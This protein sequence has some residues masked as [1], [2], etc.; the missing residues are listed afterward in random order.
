MF[1]FPSWIAFLCVAAASVLW[2]TYLG[3]WKEN[4]AASRKKSKLQKSLTQS[5]P[6]AKNQSRKN[7]RKDI[8][9]SQ[10]NHQRLQ[11]RIDSE[12]SLLTFQ[13][14]DKSNSIEIIEQLNGIQC[15]SQEKM[16]PSNKLT[17]HQ[18]RYLQA[19]EGTYHYKTQTFEAAKAVL[20]L[21]KI[22]GMTLSTH[23]DPKYAFLKGT[24]NAVSFKVEKGVPSFKASEFKAS[25]SQ[26]AK[27]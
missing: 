5:A 24:A 14:E 4:A 17:S 27:P 15:W 23:P 21:Y 6:T 20:A 13:K 22:P 12:T 9:I 16:D 8:W 25:L 7:V 2:M 18:M 19:K 3:N 11:N 10:S 26:G 1:R